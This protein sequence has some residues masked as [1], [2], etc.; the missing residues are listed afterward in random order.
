MIRGKKQGLRLLN[1]SEPEFGNWA[2]SA[3]GGASTASGQ[4][5][6]FLLLVYSPKALN[7]SLHTFKQ[8]L[9]MRTWFCSKVIEGIGFF[10]LRKDAIFF[11]FLGSLSDS[12]SI[13]LSGQI[14]DHIIWKYNL[15]MVNYFRGMKLIAHPTSS[16]L[17]PGLLCLCVGPG[18]G[19]SRGGSISWRG[20]DPW[21]HQRGERRARGP[22]DCGDTRS[23]YWPHWWQ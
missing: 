1:L 5:P 13:F 6:A 3:N 8:L 11:F 4:T 7:S 15:C 9:M 22:S 10:F 12:F 23:S 20:W 19:G 2:Q 17:L 18:V 21:C 14:A 16:L